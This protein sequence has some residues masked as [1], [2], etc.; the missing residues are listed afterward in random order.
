MVD[1][2]LERALGRERSRNP[3]LPAAL[4]DQLR[5]LAVGLD[6]LGYDPVAEAVPER[7]AIIASGRDYLMYSCLC[8]L[9]QQLS[10]P[11]EKSGCA[12]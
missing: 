9:L 12:D 5:A 6:A 3:A 10:A 8:P 2:R 11:P 4:G 7:Q 1:Q